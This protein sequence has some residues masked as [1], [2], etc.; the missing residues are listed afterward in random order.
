MSVVEHTQARV[1]YRFSAAPRVSGCNISRVSTSGR[2]ELCFCKGITV[3][4][5]EICGRDTFFELPFEIFAEARFGY[6]SFCATTASF[7]SFLAHVS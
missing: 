4:S 3:F 7:E 2:W 5:T 1:V 6:C